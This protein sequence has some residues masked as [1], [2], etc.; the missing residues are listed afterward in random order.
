MLATAPGIQASSRMPPLPLLQPDP[1]PPQ[2]RAPHHHHHHRARCPSARGSEQCCLS[3]STSHVPFNSF[4][5]GSVLPLPLMPS[6]SN[7]RTKSLWSLPCLESHTA[8]SPWA[9]HPTAAGIRAHHQPSLL[10]SSLCPDHPHTVCLQEGSGNLQRAPVCAGLEPDR[11][12]P[13]T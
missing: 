13:S 1:L 10:A 11:C 3:R 5:V 2:A 8:L 4:H 9:A 12:F 7:A 6:S